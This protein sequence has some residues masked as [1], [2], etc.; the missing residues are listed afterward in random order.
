MKGRTRAAIVILLTTL[1]L[2]SSAG[3]ERAI[4]GAFDDRNKPSSEIKPLPAFELPMPRGDADKNYLGLSGTGT[5]KI[6]QIR[7]QIVI[8][9]FFSSY[10]PHCEKA[11][12]LVAKVYDEIQRRPDLRGKITMIGIGVAT[13]ASSANL[14]RRKFSI[15]FPLF[16][17]DDMTISRRLSVL[18]TPAFMAARLNRNGVQERFY[19]YSGGIDDASRFLADIVRTSGLK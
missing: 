1:A 13:N 16:P 12:P 14:F 8:I 11:A 5:F 10:C 4:A 7:S 6:N 19:F 9:E 2:L 15:P 18:G 3:T 17:D